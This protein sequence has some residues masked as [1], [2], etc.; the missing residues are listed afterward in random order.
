M[1]DNSLIPFYES[2]VRKILHNSEWYF[3]V[4]DIV[5]VLTDSSIPRNYWS[6]LKK[7]EPQLHTICMQ[8]K[9]KSKDGKNYKTDCANTEGVLRI[10]MS[11]PSPKAEPFKMWLANV[12]KQFLD[13]TENP[14]IG[15][16]RLRELYKAKGYDDIWIESRL[17]SIG[18][19]RDLTD[20]W[21]KRGVKD[22]REYAILTAEIAKM[23]FG[24]TPSEH[25]KLKGLEKQNLRDHMTNI[26]LLFSAIGEE[27]TRM[28]SEKL[29]AQG[30]EENHDAAIKGGKAAGEARL[31]FEKNT[32]DSVVSA[33]NFLNL[34]SDNEKK[35][36]PPD[37]V[38]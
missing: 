19:R 22:N 7:R 18:I 2:N 30:Y 13:E 37:E 14:E 32:G 27:A 35:E 36:L 1:E 29:D 15:F 5:E 31:T 20:E 3:S 16:E 17:K 8:L 10:L 23:T 28:F 26:E 24:L 34:L 33:T 21:K 38:E 11:I 12:G 25:K 6:I 4:V 9:L